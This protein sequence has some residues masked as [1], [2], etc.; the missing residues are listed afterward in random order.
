MFAGLLIGCLNFAAVFNGWSVEESFEALD[1]PAIA[2][3][4]TIRDQII[5]RENIPLVS[6]IGILY[7][8]AAVIISVYWIV[9]GFFLASVF[10]FIRIVR[11]KSGATDA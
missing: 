10:C 9:I 3:I 4:E 7:F 11:K 6:G 8:L 2:L 1:R 5:F